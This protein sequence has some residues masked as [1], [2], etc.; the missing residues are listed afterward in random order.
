[1]DV[2][3]LSFHLLCCK[4]APQLGLMGYWFHCFIFIFSTWGFSFFLTS[5]EY[6][7]LNF[8]SDFCLSVAGIGGSHISDSTTLLNI[9]VLESL[10]YTIMSRKLPLFLPVF[11]LPASLFYLP[12]FSSSDFLGLICK[13]KRDRMPMN[14]EHI[15]FQT[16]I[17]WA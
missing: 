13:K 4:L 15:C 8:I 16:S 6:L 3:S 10:V 5:S 11:S 2:H 7:L 1:M 12:S 9:W 17:L 14:R